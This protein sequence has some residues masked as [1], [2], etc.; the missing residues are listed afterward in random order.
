MEVFGSP[1]NKKENISR[2]LKK[3]K[4]SEENVLSIGTLEDLDAAAS[5]D[6]Q[7]VLR[8]TKLN[9]HLWQRENIFMVDDFINKKTTGMSYEESS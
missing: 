3:T 1:S 6:I 2:I 8:K 7:F 5:F 9:K 4:F